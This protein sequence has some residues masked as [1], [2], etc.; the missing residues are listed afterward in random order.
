MFRR[1]RS[2]IVEEHV[3]RG[4]TQACPRATHLIVAVVEIHVILFADAGDDVLMLIQPTHDRGHIGC[5]KRLL[6]QKTIIVNAILAVEPNDTVELNGDG[7]EHN[8]HLY[9]R[10]TGA[11][12]DLDIVGLQ[13]MQCINCGLRHDVR[14]ETRQRSVNVEKR[15]FDVDCGHGKHLPNMQFRNCS[16]V[17]V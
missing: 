13:S 3:R 4:F 6:F 12:E 9:W 1:A 7:I 5:V 15:R 8:A 2:R 16:L 17:S 10:A 11:N 14:G